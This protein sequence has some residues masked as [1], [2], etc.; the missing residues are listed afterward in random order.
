MKE[1]N[2]STVI[3][4]LNHCKV[5]AVE[6]NSPPRPTR[7]VHMVEDNPGANQATI[8][9]QTKKALKK[10]MCTRPPKVNAS[11]WVK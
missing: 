10:R 9:P 6:H 3:N 4:D 11:D 2:S 5:C 8:N 1:E 7:A